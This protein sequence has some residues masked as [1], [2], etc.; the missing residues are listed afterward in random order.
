MGGAS[1]LIKSIQRGTISLSGATS[2]TATITSVVTANSVVRYLGD[3]QSD[4]ATDDVTF[5]ASRLALTNATTVTGSSIAGNASNTQIISYEVVEYFPGVLKSVQR[6]TV[7]MTTVTSKTATITSVDT[8]KSTV[9]HLGFNS[10]WPATP[11]YGS[12]TRA[13]WA[14]TNATTVTATVGNAS[15]ASCSLGYQ[16]AE[17]VQ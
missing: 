7:D 8:T 1:A 10:N 11:A 15:N 9:D 17:F 13:R 14:L 12:V 16:V 6:G 4:P 2:G 5:F 3:S